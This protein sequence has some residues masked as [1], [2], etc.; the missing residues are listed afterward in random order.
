MCSELPK[1]KPV[2]LVFG[3]QSTNRAG[4]SREIYDASI[5][6]RHYLD[7]CDITLQSLNLTSLYPGIFILEP[8]HDVV[9]LHSFLFSLKYATAKT[10]IECGVKPTALV[11]H[12][13]GQLTALCVSGAI[14]FGDALRLVTGRAALI[15]EH[16]GLEHGAMMSVDAD[17]NEVMDLIARAK[18]AGHNMEIA[19]FN[20]P[21]N[22]ILV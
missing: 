8:I 1:P 19:R 17:I 12:R 13:F 14:S 7:N 2:V 6:L 20:G 16:W 11:G 9:R 18:I 4:L 15:E 22:H 5:I 10:W 3:G 21:S